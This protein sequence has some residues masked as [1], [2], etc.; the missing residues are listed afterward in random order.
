MTQ[1]VLRMDRLYNL[2]PEILLF[3]VQKPNDNE[4]FLLSLVPY[5]EKIPTEHQLNFRMELMQCVSKWIG[6]NT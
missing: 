2:S 3:A 5:F 6:K 4:L 1:P